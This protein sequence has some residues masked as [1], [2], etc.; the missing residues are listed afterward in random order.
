L[1]FNVICFLVS[2]R[3]WRQGADAVQGIYRPK[4]GGDN[5]IYGDDL[6]S[7]IKTNK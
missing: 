7:I 4:K 1:S 5:E 2:C 3:P 6:E